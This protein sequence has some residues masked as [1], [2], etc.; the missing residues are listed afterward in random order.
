VD[1][2]G[3]Q[4]LRRALY[5]GDG[6]AALAAVQAAGLTKSLQLLGDV[7]RVALAQDVDGAD[8]LAKRCSGVLRA[9]GWVGDDELADALDATLGIGTSEP[10]KEIPV[11]LDELA[12]LL[13]SGPD[14][15]GGRIDLTTGEVWPEFALDP[16][17]TGEELTE[18]EEDEDRWLFV[19]PLGSRRAFQDMVDF[20]ATRQDH[21]LTDRLE[22]A[23][24]GRGAFRRFKN[25]LAR[26][27][28][29][30]DDWYRFSEDRRRGRARAW[31]ADAGYRPT[32][33]R[34]PQ[35]E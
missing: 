33:R 15:E 24:D 16:A 8:E 9:R 35:S 5:A 34:P 21:N 19:D 20:I 6:P 18:E 25:V 22:I 30:E 7:V 13:D 29:D 23:L 27:P 28:D 3:L 31:L 14:S 2:T 10:L 17:M 11:D 4:E 32:V 12:G 26:W 1:S